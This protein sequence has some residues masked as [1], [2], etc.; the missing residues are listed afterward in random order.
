MI[1]L[2]SERRRW[3]RIYGA[4]A[5]LGMPSAG[6]G[7]QADRLTP[8]DLFRIEYAL[9]PQISADGEWIAYVRQW[10]D[11]M[12]DQYYSN[13]WLI[14]SD[15]TA[16]RPLTTGK[17][18]ER[19]PRW[20]PNGQR[21]VF[22][23]NRTG[24]P[25][26]HIQWRDSSRSRAVT[27]VAELPIAPTW[28]PAGD[29][30]AFLKLVPKSPLVVGSPLHPPHGA[31]WAPAPKYTTELVYRFD[32]VGDVS[33]GFTH[34]F[35]ISSDGGTL[36]Q[37]TQGDV[38]Y[39]PSLFVEPRIAWAPDGSEIVLPARR[40]DNP[41]MY[42]FES[43]LVAVDVESGTLRR[44]TQRVGP[45]DSPAISPDGRLIAYTGYDDRKQS[46]HTTR[47]YVMN[48]DGSEKRVLS[49]H[50][51]RSMGA[52]QW[53]ANGR[54]VYVAF[55]DAGITKV[56]LLD[57]DGT[58]RVVAE[59]V[60][61]GG[62]AYGGGSFVAAR[63]GS[64]VFTRTAATTPS[65]LAINSATASRDLTTLNDSL[66]SHRALGQ[67]EEIRYRSSKDGRMIHGWLLKPPG[68][69]PTRKYPVI[70]E[71]H[72]GPF[73]NYGD[74]FDVEKQLMAAHGYVVLFVNPRGST[75]YGEEFASLM[76]QAFP[77]DERFDLIAGLD[78][79]VQRGYIDQRNQFVTGG[80]GGGALTAWLI[81]H[82]DRFRA[83]VAF[84]LVASWESTV[85][86]GDLPGGFDRMF[87][88]LPWENR[89]RYF[90]RSVLSVVNRV[91]TPTLIMTG[92]HDFRTP[93]NESEQ[94]YRALKLLGVEAALVRV[95]EASHGIWARPS[96]VASKMT[97]A[98]GWFE[99]YRI[100]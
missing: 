49:G 68:F 62:S 77:G 42:L 3:V 96:Q 2:C 12:T 92:E 40:A 35:V 81:G 13:I 6:A 66:L 52:P 59:N 7:G 5:A 19:S 69:D 33:P 27:S 87:P 46:F 34:L 51:D 26:I 75:S 65:Q 36:R 41:D 16:H 58:L 91:K 88:G 57:L 45:D 76:H 24:S 93:L 4:V 61:T 50:L 39:S 82:S 56:G 18:F 55:D 79:V 31:A 100:R 64:V 32:G 21:L 17:F 29:R 74:R 23:S 95:P 47:V 73:A 10:A 84:Y 71:I 20:S 72:G 30:I 83:A 43:D 8:M 90:A 38:H 1:R 48:R 25:Q 9:D 99:K 53:A 86:G 15:G 78:A 80:S 11:V 67:T 44:L 94:Y 63:N 14:R 37:L 97:T 28:S 85:L 89:D 60:G 22:V 54:G 98:V 70:L